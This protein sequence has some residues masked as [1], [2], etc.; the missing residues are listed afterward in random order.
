MGCA[1]E[2]RPSEKTLDALHNIVRSLDI[3]LWTGE[4]Y[5]VQDIEENVSIAKRYLDELLKQFKQEVGYIDS[6]IKPIEPPN[7]KPW[8]DPVFKKKE[9]YVTPTVPVTETK[10][11]KK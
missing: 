6:D 2:K 3:E 1:R 9:W 4:K 8:V 11:P 7:E 5:R 10:E